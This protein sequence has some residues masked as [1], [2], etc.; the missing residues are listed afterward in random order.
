[1]KQRATAHGSKW[2]KIGKNGKQWKVNT[3]RPQPQ[4]LLTVCKAEEILRK[5][6]F[7]TRGT[8]TVWSWTNMRWRTS[9]SHTRRTR[10]NLI[11]TASDIAYEPG[12]E[13]KH[14]RIDAQKGWL[15]QTTSMTESAA[16]FLQTFVLLCQLDPWIQQACSSFTDFS[17]NT[18][19]STCFLNS[20]EFVTANA[21]SSC[22]AWLCTLSWTEY[23]ESSLPVEQDVKTYQFLSVWGHDPSTHVRG[24]TE[25]WVHK[26]HWGEAETLWKETNTIWARGP[27]RASETEKERNDKKRYSGFW[28]NSEASKVFHAQHLEGKERSSR[29]WKMTKARQSHPEKELRMSSVHFTAS[30]YAE[31]R[32][33]EE[34]QD[35]QS[36][37]IRMNTEQKSYHEDLRN[38]IPEFT[39]GEIQAAIDSLRKGESKWQ[40][41]PKTLRQATKRQKKWSDRSSTKC[42]SRRRTAHQKHEGEYV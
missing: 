5:I 3:Q 36:L 30:W 12:H 27:K 32:L 37:E 34:V 14:Q 2:P 19:V 11:D 8:W 24:A 20:I 26:T 25:G 38:E 9:R 17:W 40:H 10:L 15:A 29:R 16:L 22:H 21:C 39:Q 41:R 18:C 28:K 35:P 42:W 31:N 1:M 4:Y 23:Q 6:Q 33:G 7:D 13:I